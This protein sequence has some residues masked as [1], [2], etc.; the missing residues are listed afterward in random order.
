MVN[1][2]SPDDAWSVICSLCVKDRRVKGINLSRNFGQHKAISAGLELSTSDYIIVMDCDLQDNPDEIPRLLTKLKEGY[3]VVLGRRVQRRDHWLK[4]N[5]SIFFYRVLSYLT[6]TQLDPAVANFGVYSRKVIDSINE[7]GDGDRFFPIMAQ[8]VGFSSA[9]IE[10]RHSERLM[11]QTSYSWWRL[12]HLAANIIL[13]FSNKPLRLIVGL[14]FYIS[15]SA[16]VYALYIF[17]HALWGGVTV[18]GWSSVIIS[19]WFFSGVHIIIMG[20][21]GLYVG[22]IFDSVKYRPIYVIKDT[23]NVDIGHAVRR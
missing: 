16:F 10:V 1:D 20:L 11:G 5:S 9:S 21:I 15:A 14:G 12:F 4:R 6:D 18:A 19:I 2:A 3:D 8:W 13:T 17:S 22:K 23:V 7:M